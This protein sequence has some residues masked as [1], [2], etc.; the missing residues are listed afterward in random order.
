MELLERE[1]SF[2]DLA[3]WL[4]AAKELGG[5]IV[6]V[7]GE[8]GIG[9]TALLQEFTRQMHDRRVLWGA[10]DAL[11]TP[12]PLAPLHDIARQTQGVLL[13]AITSGASRDAIF[14][15]ALDELERTETLAVFE[16]LHWADQATLALLHYVGRRINRPRAMLAVTYRYDQMGRP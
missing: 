2:A 1:R 16:D 13:A 6:L 12:R 5:C 14:S 8:A 11:I 9:K 3:A 7:G 10:C 4:D 15:A